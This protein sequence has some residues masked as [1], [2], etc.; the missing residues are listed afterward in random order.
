M[1]GAVQK[2]QHRSLQSGTLNNFLSNLVL[3]L[4][5]RKGAGINMNNVYTIIIIVAYLTNL[6]SVLSLLFFDK[7]NVAS[8]LNWLMVF[9]F[10]PLV[11]FLLYFFLG[12]TVKF[13]LFSKKTDIE[14]LKKFSNYMLDDTIKRVEQRELPLTAR[15]KILYNDVIELNAKSAESVYTVN[16]SVVLFPGAQ[17]KYEAL[18]EDIENATES[19]HMLYFII[20]THDKSG[21]HLVKLLAKKAAEGVEVRL[22][23]DMLGFFGVKYSDFKE[24]TDAGGM[25]YPFLP[26]VLRTLLQANYRMHRKLVIIDGQIAYTGGINIGDDY[27]GMDPKVKP[28]R[29]T[30]VKITGPAVMALQLRFLTDWNYL[31][32][33]APKRTRYSNW[34]GNRENLLNYFKAP[35]NKGEVGIQVLSSGPDTKYT[36]I[37]DSYVKMTMSAKRYL[38][39]QTPYLIPDDILLNALRLAVYS[40]VDVRIM[41]PGVPDKRF[42]YAATLS[43]VEQL[44]DYGIKIYCYKGFIHAKTFVIDDFIASIGSANVDVRSFN[45][46]YE[47]TTMMYN[48]EFAVQCKETFFNDVKNSDELDK[49]SF[50]KRGAFQKLK[51]S[52]WRLITPIM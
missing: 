14:P 47:L 13:R 22:I 8:T 19:I 35:E 9:I 25:V 31:D 34:A 49:E 43:Y 41:I 40:G 37:K 24:L 15:E 30:S 17:E 4:E 28:W 23:Y 32:K 51:E 46:N 26:S 38:Y 16:N 33:Q 7:R 39:I 21:K 45:I 27:L 44:L 52:F 1:F 36:L 48:K 42:V 3:C 5:S 2:V 18:F 12:S 10:L 6:I 20:K 50:S 11:G 29:D